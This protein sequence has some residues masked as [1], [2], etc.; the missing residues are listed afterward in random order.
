[1]K[2]IVIGAVAGGA[3]AAARLRRLDEQAEITMFEKGAYVSYAN[4][5]LPY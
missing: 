5:G 2:Y 1:M 3:S 4:W